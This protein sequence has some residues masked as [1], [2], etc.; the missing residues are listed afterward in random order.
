M[1]TNPPRHVLE[2]AFDRIK[3]RNLGKNEPGLLVPTSL[4]PMEE[5][6]LFSAARSCHVLELGA[7]WGEFA[8]QWSVSHPDHEYTAFEINWDRIRKLLNNIDKLKLTNLKIIPMNFVWFMDEILPA[9]SFDLVIVNFPDPWP[10]RRHRKHRLIDNSFPGRMKKILRPG[11]E[12]SI[13]TDYGPY[14]RKILS[15]FRKAGAFSSVYRNPDYIRKTPDGYPP[16]KFETIF[17]N[18]K[19]TPYYQRWKLNHE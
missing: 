14:A 17:L 2:K 15:I 19:R 1:S 5:T 12:I 8:V 3:Q 7:G 9:H 4:C 13:A 16:T 6:A 10:K 11:G 18:Q